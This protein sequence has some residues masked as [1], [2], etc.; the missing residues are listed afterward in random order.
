MLIPSPA[1]EPALDA[2]EARIK[3]HLDHPAFSQF[4]QVTVTK[5]EA[6]KWSKSWALDQSTQAEKRVM[7]EMLLGSGAPLARRKGCELMLA[8][9]ARVRSAEV[10]RVRQ[11]MA[12][13]PSKFLPRADLIGAFEAWRRVQVR[14]LFRLSL[15]ALFYWIIWQIEDGPCFTEALVNAFLDQAGRP[16]RGAAR[17]WLEAS[18]RLQNSPTALMERIGQAMDDE[19]QTELASAVADSLSFCISEAPERGQIFERADRLPLFRVRREAEVWGKAPTKNFLRHVLEIMGAGTAC[20]LGSWS[21]AGRCTS[22]REDDSPSEGRPGGR[23][24]D[25][26]SRSIA[27]PATCPNSR[28]AGDCARLWQRNAD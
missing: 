17:L 15:E 28:Q 19:S 22:A 18:S 3:R 12:G 21:G 26:G 9:V 5:R 23:R 14:Q 10:A 4:G 2:F 1:A 20:V 24:V 16:K 25:F 27:G 7:A 13:A 6:K 8:S 11:T